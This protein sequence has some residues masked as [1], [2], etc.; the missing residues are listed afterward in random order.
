MSFRNQDFHGNKE[1]QFGKSAVWW[2][3]GV[4]AIVSV[5]GWFLLGS[6][7]VVKQAFI[8]YEEFETI[9]NTCTQIDEKLQNLRAIP[10]TDKAFEQFSKAQQV[11]ALKSS[12]TKWVN[13]YNAKSKLWHRSMWKSNKLPY[14]LNVNDYPGY[15]DPAVGY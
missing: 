14:Q 1:I 3:L 4:I 2:V 13:D 9:Y 6:G 15:Y 10:E 7:R 5:A 11:T 8:D 12:M